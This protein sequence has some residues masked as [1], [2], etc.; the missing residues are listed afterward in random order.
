MQPTKRWVLLETT[1]GSSPLISDVAVIGHAQMRRAQLET[2]KA[3]QVGPGLKYPYLSPV[4]GCWKSVMKAFDNFDADFTIL[5]IF[6]YI[7]IHMY[8]FTPEI[9]SWWNGVFCGIII[10]QEEPPNSALI[11]ELSILESHL[12]DLREWSNLSNPV[13]TSC[14]ITCLKIITLSICSSCR[15]IWDY[16]CYITF[17]LLHPSWCI[18]S[19]TNR[20]GTKCN[21]PLH[22]LAV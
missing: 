11:T 15:Y 2:S 3:S 7:Y 21:Y 9:E 17:K 19:V 4:F 12:L 13:I 10:F 6:I 5:F 8:R 14:S 22:V 20:I 16:I 1:P 18:V